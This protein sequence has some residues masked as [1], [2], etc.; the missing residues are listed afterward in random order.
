MI[1]SDKK[2]AL[3]VV[4]DKIDETRKNTTDENF[5]NQYLGPVKQVKPISI[6][7]IY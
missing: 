1:L 3:D 7:K 5:E 4:E 2:E 6:L